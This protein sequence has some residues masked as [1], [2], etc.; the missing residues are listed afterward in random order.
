MRCDREDYKRWV[1]GEKPET[2]SDEQLAGLNRDICSECYQ[3]EREQLHE[4]G[5]KTSS[6]TERSGPLSH[7]GRATHRAGHLAFDPLKAQTYELISA[8]RW[9]RSRLNLS[10]REVADDL[11]IDVTNLH[12]WIRGRAIPGED[13]RQL[14]RVGLEGILPQWEARLAAGVMG[15]G[16]SYLDEDN[17]YNKERAHAI[18]VADRARS[19]HRG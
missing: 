11:G 13:N 19:T 3:K 6:P 9:W 1:D 8:L 10:W 5:L 12:P 7:G 17:R 2:L 14:V 4:M 16:R 15:Q 18:V